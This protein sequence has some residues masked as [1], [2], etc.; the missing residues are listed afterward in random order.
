MS[1]P[2]RTRLWL[3]E[4]ESRLVPS[5]TVEPTP[6]EDVSASVEAE[7]RPYVFV[8][9]AGMDN[10]PRDGRNDF[11]TQL[12]I[13]VTNNDG[14]TAMITVSIQP[15]QTNESVALAVASALRAEGYDVDVNGSAITIWGR[16]DAEVENVAVG[17]TGATVGKD[18][19]DLK[20]PRVQGHNGATGYGY[21]ALATTV[22]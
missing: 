5:A 4:I 21:V 8:D 20:P 7:A 13:S 2:F 10:A 11:A 17:V 16:G 15:G 22:E 19:H 6:S 18:H 14:S 9:F 12:T 3:D 1:S